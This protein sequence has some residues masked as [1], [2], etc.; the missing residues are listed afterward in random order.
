MQDLIIDEELCCYKLNGKP[1]FEDLGD[2]LCL[3]PAFRKKTDFPF[4]AHHTQPSRIF[5]AERAERIFC[6]GGGTPEAFL[7]LEVFDTPRQMH[8]ELISAVVAMYM[9]L[10]GVSPPSASNKYDKVADPRIRQCLIDRVTRFDPRMPN[11][12]LQLL[13][14][15]IEQAY[16]V[17]LHADCFPSKPVP[18]WKP[19]VHDTIHELYLWRYHGKV[20]ENPTDKL[21]KVVEAMKTKL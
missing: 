2:G 11:G 16:Q 4:A 18:G 6:E 17:R 14:A 8:Q 12:P 10:A 7:P 19:D 9:K 1:L 20:T 21:R 5:T 13:M 15:Q 3:I